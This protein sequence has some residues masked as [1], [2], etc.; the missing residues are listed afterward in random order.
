MPSSALVTQL[1]SSLMRV[2]RTFPPVAPCSGPVALLRRAPAPPAV[3]T[4]GEAAPIIACRCSPNG[5][6]EAAENRYCGNG[7]DAAI[8]RNRG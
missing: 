3:S 6:Y 2:Y 5:D 4:T 8:T 1:F 7:R